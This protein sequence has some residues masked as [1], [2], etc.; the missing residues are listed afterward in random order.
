MI[1]DD[2]AEGATLTNTALSTATPPGLPP[3]EPPHVT[4]EH[5]VP[6]YT[7]KKSSDPASGT[8]VKRGA[9]INYTVTGTNTGATVLDPVIINDDL[10]QVLNSAELSGTPVAVIIDSGGI[11]TQAAAP[12]LTGT[13]LNWQGVLA[14]GERVELRYSVQIG[15]E[16]GKV[17]IENI[18]TSTAMPP[19]GTEIV[20]P[21][22]TTT[23]ET[24]EPPAP[25]FPGLPITGEN[26]GIAAGFGVVLLLLGAAVVLRSRRKKLAATS[27]EV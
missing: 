25:L 21:P 20:P 18:V 17:T 16:V 2:G 10:A 15:D 1:V 12:V 9:T 24:P 3:I 22:A 8:K 14:V 23:H 7:L 27:T 6:G 13:T 26:L 19:G 4:T 5:P 11:E